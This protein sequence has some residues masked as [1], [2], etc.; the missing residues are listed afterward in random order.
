MIGCIAMGLVVDDTVHF[1]VHLRRH[2]AKGLALELAI[3][4]TVV[5]AGRAITMTS[6]ILALGFAVLMLGKFA[7]NRHFGLVTAIVVL[8]ALVADLVALPAAL[9]VFRPEI[10]KRRESAERP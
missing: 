6:L 7:P 2:L 3:Q 5:E 1:L 4:R 8:L 10:G 9:R